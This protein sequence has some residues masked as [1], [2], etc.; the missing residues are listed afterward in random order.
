MR[1]TEEVDGAA[2]KSLL[3]GRE[4]PQATFGSLLA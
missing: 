4:T 2:D 1:L 3:D